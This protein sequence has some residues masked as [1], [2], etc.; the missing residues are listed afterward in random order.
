MQSYS[1]KKAIYEPGR[2]LSP[3]AESVGALIQT[4]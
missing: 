2:G 1:E 4:P 3:D